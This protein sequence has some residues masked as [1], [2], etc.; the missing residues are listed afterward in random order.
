MAK[1]RKADLK[2]AKKK[3]ESV[4]TKALVE[5]VAQMEE[6]WKRALA[7]YENLRKRVAK[8]KDETV[9]FANE[10][11]IDKILFVF[12]NLERACEHLHDKGLA[13]VRDDFWQ[14]LSSEGVKRIET[15]GKKFDPELMDAVAVVEGKKNIVQEEVLPGY[16]YRGKCIRPAKVKVGKG[17]GSD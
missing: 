3:E 11:L 14:V 8:E 1:T 17:R 12:D 10:M 6:Q 4:S 7:D 15:E 2:K 5:K 16:L 9:R 13:M